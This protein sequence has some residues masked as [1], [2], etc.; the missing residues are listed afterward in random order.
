MK[1]SRRIFA[2]IFIAFS[3]I[4]FLPA[5]VPSAF[6]AETKTVQKK[7]TGYVASNLEGPNYHKPSCAMV[8]KIKPVNRIIFKTEKEAEKAGYTPCA[9]CWPKK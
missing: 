9:V 1:L 8:A 7:E 2:A 5:A 3:L 4:V 6:A